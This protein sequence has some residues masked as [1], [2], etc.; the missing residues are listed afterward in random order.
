MRPATSQYAPDFLSRRIA[1]NEGLPTVRHAGSVGRKEV[2]GIAP[3]RSR[4]FCENNRRQPEARRKC[5]R[6]TFARAPS[7]RSPL[8]APSAGSQPHLPGPLPILSRTSS[9][10]KCTTSWWCRS[11][12]A[13]VSLK[14][15][16]SRCSRFDFVGSGFGACGPSTL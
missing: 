15:S 4:R 16:H 5:A 8:D 1:H 13:T 2:R 3:A 9:N 14:R 6:F 12:G 11:S 10:A 7:S